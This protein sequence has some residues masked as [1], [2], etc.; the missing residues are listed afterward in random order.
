MLEHVLF[1]KPRTLFLISLYGDE[2]FRIV[3]ADKFTYLIS[4]SRIG[5]DSLYLTRLKSI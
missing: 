1:A 3:S 4:V 2:S 5:C